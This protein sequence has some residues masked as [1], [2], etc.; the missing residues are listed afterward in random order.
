MRVLIADDSKAMRMIILRCLRHSGLDIDEVF[1]AADGASAL[2]A[3]ETFAP[4][5]IL[6]DWDIPVVTGLDLLQAVRATGA[7]TVFGF[8]TAEI[9]VEVREQAIAAGASFVATKPIDCERVG[10]LVGVLVT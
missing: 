10:E 1:E 8:I 6:S 5:L 3:V 9:S 7:M 2:A 4:D